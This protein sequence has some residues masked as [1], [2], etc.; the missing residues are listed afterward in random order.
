[1]SR[2]SHLKLLYHLYFILHVDAQSEQLDQ[3]ESERTGLLS[4]REFVEASFLERGG[5]QEKLKDTRDRKQTNDFLSL[6]IHDAHQKVVSNANEIEKIKKNLQSTKLELTKLKSALQLHVV[7][8]NNH[9]EEVHG[10]Q[11]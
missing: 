5:N 11:T 7:D 10:S 9:V 4:E 8:K 2:K 6:M 3:L 1:M